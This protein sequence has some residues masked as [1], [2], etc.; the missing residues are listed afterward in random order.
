M[1]GGLTPE[2]LPLSRVRN[3]MG[4]MKEK[5]WEWG[6]GFELAPSASATAYALDQ[7][8][9]LILWSNEPS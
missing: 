9:L 4:A 1:G 8:N 5:D 7:F 3:T 6:E 2:F